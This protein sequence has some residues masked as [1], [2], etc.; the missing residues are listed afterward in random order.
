MNFFEREYEQYRVIPSDINEN[1]HYL[2]ELALKCNHVTEMG[3]RTG[4]ST[5]A[6]LNTNAT[7]ISYDFEYNS[8]VALLFE[9][10]NEYAKNAQYIIADV[11]E[12]EIE[13]TDLLFI[14]TWHCY[15][16]LK[17]EL[18]LHHKKVRKYIAFHDTYTYG[19]I[20]ED[21]Y[22]EKSQSGLGLLPAIVEFMT[23]NP[24]WKFKMNVTNNNGLM[25]L[26]KESDVKVAEPIEEVVLNPI[27]VIGVPIVNG[28]H[29]LKRLIE[30]IDYPVDEVCIINNNGRGELD[31]ELYQLALVK[32]DFIGKI[33]ICTLPSNIGCSGA[34]NLIIKSYL[35]KPYWVL[36]NHDIAF[37]NGYLKEMVIKAQNKEVGMVFPT[38]KQEWCSF[39]LKDWV[40][41]QCGLFDEN[42]YPAYCEDIDYALRVQSIGVKCEDVMLPLLHGDKGYDESGSQTWRTD[43]SLYPKIENAHNLNHDYMAQ[44]WGNEWKEKQYQ[45]TPYK[46]P[47]NDE[48]MLISTTTY[49]LEFLRKKHL[50]F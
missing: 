2:H 23:E 42:F 32:Y 45:F 6:F 47:F 21:N 33:T 3:V 48:K 15:E 13:E 8:D 50:G 11:R 5:R 1:L 16:Q 22:I 40:V 37:T 24:E 34:W 25:I 26:E 38:A 17:T 10:A 14:D 31:Y 35:L 36:C 12:V 7:L 19:L 49:D 28:V 27:P 44:K 43:M 29:W 46:Y 18:A 41:Q 20:A 30:S 9:K 39:L 4:I